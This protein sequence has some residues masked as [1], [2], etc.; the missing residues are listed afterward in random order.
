VSSAQVGLRDSPLLGEGWR[1]AV[2]G[3]VNRRRHRLTPDRLVA[4]AVC[5]R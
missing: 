2:A 4:A 5:S 3:H 1:L